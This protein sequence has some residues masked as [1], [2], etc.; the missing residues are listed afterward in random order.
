MLDQDRLAGA[1]TGKHPTDLRNGGVRLVDHQQEILWKKI[2]QRARARAGR[3]GVE[4]ARIILDAGAETHLKHHLEV[5]LGAHPDALGLKQ[6]P[7]FLQ[8]GHALAKL[9]ANGLAGALDV[10]HRRD[11]LLAGKDDHARQRLERVPGQRVEPGDAIDLVAEKL[12]ANPLLRFCR[13]YLDRV[14]AHAKL[15]AL[16]LDIIA[17]VLNLNQARQQA[18]PA[19]LLADAEADDHFLEVAFFADTVDARD[20]GDDDHVAPGEERTHRRETKSLDLVVD[21]G[22][23]LDEC[24][25]LR[26]VGFRLVVVEVTYKILDGVFR[27]EPLELGV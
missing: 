3:A 25:G 13:A 23:L 12:D 17:L 10:L 22:V 1:I 27:E 19:K 21:A 9:V 8:L 11:E 2:D 5:I 14:A 4:V 6:F 24:V 18:L 20:A 7:V 26:D 16:K 15:A